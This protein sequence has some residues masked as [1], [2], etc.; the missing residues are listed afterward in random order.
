MTRVQDLF[1]DGEYRPATNGRRF[2]DLSP[3][4]GEV[5]REVAAAATSDAT[6]AVDAAAGAFRTWSRTSPAERRRVLLRAAD[7]LESEIETHRSMFACETGSVRGWADMNVR[8]AASTLREAAGLTT[9]AVG[10]LLPSNETGTLNVSSRVPAGVVLAIVPWNAPLILA[11]RSFAIAV[12][13]GNTVVIRP[14]EEAPLAAGFVLADTLRRAGL[15][16][17]V[18]NVVSTGPAEGPQVIAELIADPRVRRVV[19][20]GSTAV[21]RKIAEIAG[22]HLTPTVLELGGKNS[23][24]VRADADLDIWVPAIAFSAFANSGQVCMCTD[25][26]IVHRS[27]A[28]EL[29]DRLAAH[30][31]S[32]VVGDPLDAET[33]LGPLINSRA[34]ANFRDLVGDAVRCGAR[35]LAGGPETD[36][37][38]ARPTVI[39]QLPREAALYHREAFSPVVSIHP[40]ADDEEAVAVAN[41]TEY[42]LVASVVSSDTA[43]AEALAQRVRAGA[44]HVN[45]PSIG[46]EPHV[47][48][49]GLGASGFGR[50]GGQESVRTFTEQRTFYLHDRGG[51]F[52]V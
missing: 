9:T 25:R 24:I 38:Y 5:Y 46:D 50:L 12:A 49:G 26:I 47:A 17:G 15:P 20:I 4:S 18:V 41:D 51:L 1:I 11:A 37:S 14:S 39:S 16:V 29:A 8:E 30:A 28:A 42:G 2:Q 3:I 35:L 10:E 31:E 27:K 48:F 21:G 19:F 13:L 23:T 43:R 40:V 52:G 32:M 22:R 7:L 36:G 6:A 44:V 45:G 33:D 34:A